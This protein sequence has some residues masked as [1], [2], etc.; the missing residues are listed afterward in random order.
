MAGEIL[1]SLC[2]PTY[3]RG[4]YLEKCLESIVRQVGNN[5]EVEIVISDNVSDDKTSEIAVSY[6]TEYSNVRYFRND[7]NIGGDKNF[8]KVLKLGNGKYLKLLNDYVEFKEGCVLKMLEIV[9]NHVENKEILFFANGISYL[10]KKDFYYSKDLDEFLRVCS[11]HS[12]WIGTI[13]FWNDDF[14]TMM[15][16][17]QFKT[18]SFFQTELLF[19]NFNLSKKAVTYTRKIFISNQVQKKNSA[20]N[21]FDVF[22]NSYFNTII[23]GLKNEKRISKSTYQKDKNRFFTDWVFNWYKKIKIKKNSNIE[24]NDKGAESIIFN[25]FK[26]SP[27]F[28]LYLLY[29]PFYMIGFYFKKIIKYFK[30]K[31]SF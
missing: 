13:G 4:T 25:T 18:K 31:R 12:Q 10:R 28:Y 14:K 2:I 5:D 8:I 27:I 29:L 17:Y 20:F 19:E 6:A 1:L 9:K 21:F 3:N 30:S 23:A 15:S 24:I 22:I 7:S 11:F 26:Y 16:Y